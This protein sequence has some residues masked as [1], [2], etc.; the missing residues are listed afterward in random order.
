MAEPARVSQPRP[1]RQPATSDKPPV[2]RAIEDLMAIRMQDLS[3]LTRAELLAL[4]DRDLPTIND[5][6]PPDL[7]E[8]EEVLIYTGPP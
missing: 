8:Q 1:G 6:P 7:V 4:T 2:E 5:L 3:G